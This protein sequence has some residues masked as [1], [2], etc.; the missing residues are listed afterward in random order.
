MRRTLSTT[1]LL[2]A[3]TLPALG[4]PV[5]DALA[6]RVGNGTLTESRDALAR[7][8]DEAP[9]DDDNAGRTRLAL[10]L[11]ETLLAAEHLVQQA[12]LHGFGEPMR[13]AGMGLLPALGAMPYNSSPTPATPE[14]IPT[15]ALE[16][17]DRLDRADRTLAAINNDA[18][19]LRLDAAQLRFDI[20]ANQTIEAD[21]VGHRLF[22]D[23]VFAGQVPPRG[24]S[25]EI[26]LDRADV[27]WLRAYCNL[28]M[29]FTEVLAAYDTS[30]LFQ[31]TGH[32]LFAE[33]ESDYPFLAQAGP[34]DFTETGFDFSD[35]IAF[36]H[37][38]NL[39]VK[40]APL[41]RSAHNRLLRATA[42]SDAMW[43][44]VLAETD[45][46]R[47]WIPG[48]NQTPAISG[49]RISEGRIRAWRTM[50][51]ETRQ[52][53][54]GERLIHFWRGDGRQ[55]INLRRAFFEPTNL[56]LVLWV[57]GSA[58]KPYLEDGELV[59]EGYW[60]DMEEAFGDD[61]M[62]YLFYIN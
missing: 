4:D 41:L 36:I 19:L 47:E 62:G 5:D 53:L 55:G 27:E 25:F 20:N 52:I 17:R 11:V 51:A 50:L 3:F 18:V 54:Q 38:I 2:A 29:G 49:V 46:D 60:R 43:G 33:V 7:L 34:F 56:D 1:L 58:A 45:D 57:Q 40:D 22:R 8:I 37:L 30:E 16:L 32:I 21:E 13:D 31:R 6:G 10:G 12:Y 59:R 9:A 26:A 23:L 42:H 28:L 61:L 39:P 35:V 14:T 44:F 48:P 15:I 24:E